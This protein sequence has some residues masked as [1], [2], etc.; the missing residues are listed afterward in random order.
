MNDHDYRLINA[1]NAYALST[2]ERRGF[3]KETCTR[4]EKV[5][6]LAVLLMQGRKTQQF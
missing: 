5:F 4:K 1:D 3:K 6:S 2:L